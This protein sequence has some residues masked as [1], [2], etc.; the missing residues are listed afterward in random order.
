VFF[1]HEVSLRQVLTPEGLLGR[2]NASGG[3]LVQGIAPLG[4]LMAGLLATATSP[5]AVLWIAAV[6]ILAAGIWVMRSPVAGLVA[7]PVREV[8]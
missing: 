1:I 4:A 7:Y 3:F 6:G 5:R 2:V 8:D